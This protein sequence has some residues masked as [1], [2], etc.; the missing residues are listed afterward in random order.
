MFGT[1]RKITILSNGAEM[2][3]GARGGRVNS[4]DVGTEH[5]EISLRFTST[6]TSPSIRLHVCAGRELED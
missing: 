2:V 1:A 5:Y 6:Y 3:I 4:A